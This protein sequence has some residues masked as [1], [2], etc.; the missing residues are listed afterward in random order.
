MVGGICVVGSLIMD[1]HSSPCLCVDAVV[2]SHVNHVSSGEVNLHRKVKVNKKLRSSF[3]DCKVQVKV[4]GL[5][6]VKRSKGFVIVSELGGQYDESFYDVKA[7]RGLTVPTLRLMQI[8][9]MRWSSSINNGILQKLIYD[10]FSWSSKEVLVGSCFT[11]IEWPEIA[12][13]I[14]LS[15][16]AFKCRDGEA[17]VVP[18][19]LNAADAITRI[20]HE[21]S[22]IMAGEGEF[23]LLLNLLN[24]VIRTL[25]QLL[26][27]PCM[28][29]YRDD[30]KTQVTR[31]L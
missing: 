16:L 9:K 3:V 14:T 29:S 22:S 7:V 30:S 31:N 17:S 26:Y 21:S 28:A 24:S 4:N 1:S 11:T 12:S 13:A 19:I 5:K 20:I 25:R 15:L 6:K 27:G 10:I 8:E 2:S 23:L 18:V